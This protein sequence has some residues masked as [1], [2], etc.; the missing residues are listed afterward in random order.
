MLEQRLVLEGGRQEDP[1]PDGISRA[2]ELDCFRSPVDEPEPR[3]DDFR[4]STRFAELARE[5]S[6]IL[7]DAS[8]ASGKPAHEWMGTSRGAKAGT[9]SVGRVAG[10]NRPS[11][12]GRHGVG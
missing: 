3:G 2:N 4:T 9:T 5:L 1:L 8:L 6:A 10:V 12:D 11:S 7:N